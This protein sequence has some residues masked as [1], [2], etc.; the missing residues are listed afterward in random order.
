[1]KEG[2]KILRVVQLIVCVGALLAAII[3]KTVD[4]PVYG[5]VRSWYQL[6]AEQ[7]VLPN[8]QVKDWERQLIPVFPSY[9]N[10]NSQI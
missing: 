3:L 7:N 5:Q 9:D 4:Q 10:S 2:E 6:Q 1:M 8:D